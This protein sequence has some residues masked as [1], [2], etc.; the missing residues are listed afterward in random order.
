MAINDFDKSTKLLLWHLK[1]EKY[2][3]ERDGYP[4]TWAMGHKWSIFEFPFPIPPHIYL[5]TSYHSISLLPVPHFP[6][7]YLEY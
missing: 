7:I 1:C 4:C 3:A 2:G 5:S 6:P